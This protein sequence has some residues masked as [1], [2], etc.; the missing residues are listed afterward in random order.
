MGVMSEYNIINLPST[1]WQINLI[2]VFRSHVQNIW[3]GLASY[4]NTNQTSTTKYKQPI[5]VAWY[6]LSYQ[7]INIWS[8]LFSIFGGYSLRAA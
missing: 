1:V 7:N 3:I 2:K 6:K 5:V 8:H 4:F